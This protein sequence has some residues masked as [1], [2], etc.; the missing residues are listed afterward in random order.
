[1][2]QFKDSGP[3][4]RKSAP[5]TVHTTVV[6]VC[7]VPLWRRLPSILSAF[8]ALAPGDAIELVVDLDPWPLRSYFDATRAGACD[9]LV[10][11]SGPQNWRVRLIRLK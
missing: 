1:L 8:D 3:R 9:W 2:P 5:V 6:D 7:R 4:W 10:I 11:E